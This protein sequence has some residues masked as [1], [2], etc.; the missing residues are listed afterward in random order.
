VLEAME[1]RVDRM[2]NCMRIRGST[3]EDPFGTIKSWQGPTHFHMKTLKHV[4][5]EISA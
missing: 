2:S 4:S 1:E 5:T 3:V